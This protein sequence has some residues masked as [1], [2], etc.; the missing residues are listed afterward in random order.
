M[1]TVGLVCYAVFLVMQLSEF[2]R[3]CTIKNRKINVHYIHFAIGWLA[4]ARAM[5]TW[6]YC[7]R[8]Q[9]ASKRSVCLAEWYNS[10]S[11]ERARE[12]YAANIYGLLVSIFSVN[13]L[14]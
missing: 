2:Y 14:Y 12:K 6:S 9:S 3:N 7:M 4:E 1:I 5:Y 13:H 8:N 11:L 10:L